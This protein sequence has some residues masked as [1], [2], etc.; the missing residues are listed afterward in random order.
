MLKVVL[1]CLATY[2]YTTD[3]LNHRVYVFATQN[4]EKCGCGVGAM[5]IIAL[6]IRCFSTE[7]P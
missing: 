1:I 5:G 3:T 2:M 6:A 4:T 7:N